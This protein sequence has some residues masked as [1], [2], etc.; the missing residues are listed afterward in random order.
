MS[1]LGEAISETSLGALDSDSPLDPFVKGFVDHAHPAIG[2]TTNDAEP[3]SGQ[4]AR[5]ERATGQALHLQLEI[6]GEGTLEKVLH[7]HLRRQMLVNAPEQVRIAA[8]C[9]ANPVF[10]LLGWLAE[11]AFHQAHQ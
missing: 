7:P 2:Y 1:R 10:A 3:P 8:A 9:A 4:S 11:S 6:R 5:F